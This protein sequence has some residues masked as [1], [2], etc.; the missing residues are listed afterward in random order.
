MFQISTYQ[1]YTHDTRTHT[2]AV[3]SIQPSRP[4]DLEFC[5]WTW[6][7]C[8][9]KS[10]SGPHTHAHTC[11]LFQLLKLADSC[12][13][14]E[15]RQRASELTPCGRAHYLF[16]SLSLLF[17]FQAV[18]L[19]IELLVFAGSDTCWDFV[20]CTTN[21]RQSLLLQMYWCGPTSRWST[22]SCP[23]VWGS[24]AAAWWK[25]A[26]TERS[27]LWMRPSTTVV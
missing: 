13:L 23:L 15:Q 16:I 10:Q 3:R 11:C 12:A 26:C 5:T 14:N 17:L 8:H 25:V 9:V 19:E 6:L 18:L 24:I 2:H 4:F 1:E 7:S 27:S 22:G 20:D 21:L